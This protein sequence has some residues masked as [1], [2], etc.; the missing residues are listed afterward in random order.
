MTKPFVAAAVD[1]VA[2]FDDG[3][4][5]LVERHGA[6]AVKLALA[7]GLTAVADGVVIDAD[8]LRTWRSQERGG[9]G[10]SVRHIWLG[11]IDHEVGDSIDSA[12]RFESAVALAN[13]SGVAGIKFGVYC[14]SDPEKAAEFIRRY[15]TYAE[16]KGVSVM[17]EPYFGRLAKRDRL[18]V[19][20]AGRG[21]AAI[22]CDVADPGRW[23]AVYSSGSTTAWLA[24]SDGT[25]FQ[26]FV[27]RLKAATAQGCSG[28]V[29]G[30]AL[31]H[32]PLSEG[33]SAD[34]VLGAIRGRLD[35]LRALLRH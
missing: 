2:A 12:E 26:A 27:P 14:E 21:A 4:F 31:W 29:I 20:A 8:T 35:Y 15:I 6:A 5:P 25:G 3:A 17:P 11:D 32:E 19:L 9:L 24:R 13:E 23:A 10:R 18:K 30:R 34:A 7:R 28:A 22:K 1:H 33:S 16:V